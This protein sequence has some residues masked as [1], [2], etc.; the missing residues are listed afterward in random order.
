[1]TQPHKDFCGNSV[2]HLTDVLQSVLA[3]AAVLGWGEAD[4]TA[5]LPAP[6]NQGKAAGNAGHQEGSAAQQHSHGQHQDQREGGGQEEAVLGRV[7]S[8]VPAEEQR[9][10][11]GHGQGAVPQGGLQ[12]AD[13]RRLRCVTL[14]LMIRS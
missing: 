4:V 13:S 10:E 1:M 7:E 14:D 9:V 8:S 3:A 12:E 2:S 5:S 6:A 11:G